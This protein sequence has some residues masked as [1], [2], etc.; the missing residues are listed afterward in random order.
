MRRSSARISGSTI[1]DCSNRAVMIEIVTNV[2]FWAPLNTISSN[3]KG[4]T[5]G[6]NSVGLHVFQPLRVSFSGNTEDTDTYDGGI[7]PW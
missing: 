1:S 6:M 3:N 2:D 7:I 5:S 4:V